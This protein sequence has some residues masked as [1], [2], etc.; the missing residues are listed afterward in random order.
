MKK[1]TIFISIASYRDDVCALTIKSLFEMAS[2]P[3]NVY[4]GICQ[5][6]KKEDQDCYNQDN[7]N[8][9]IIR[10]PHYEAR[11]PTYARYLCSTL[12]NGEEYYLQIDSHTKFV[13]DWDVKCIEM[14]RK[15]KEITKKPVL[16]H[17]PRDMKDYDE[18]NKHELPRIC[19]AFF[20]DRGMIS[21]AGSEIMDSKNQF[22][23]TP[24]I[25]AGM[26]FC[27]S[28]FLNELPFDPN[29]PYLFTGE[30]ILLSVRFY[31]NGWDIYTPTENVL[32]HEY[33]R[34]EK[35]KIWS[36]DSHY[37]DY[38]AVNKVKYYLKLKDAGKISKEMKINIDKYGLGKSRTLEDYYKFAGI[39]IKNNKVSKNFCNN[40]EENFTILY[41][42]N[43]NYFFLFFFFIL[44]FILLL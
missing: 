39:D 28:Y 22:Y 38:E 8:V 44:F 2:R 21:F 15:L 33:T 37:S 35:P 17:Y 4:V 18:K 19:K 1:D 27:E 3:E 36:D 26:F 32:F 11:G 12:W 42:N 23:N 25:A 41:N 13:K 31:T 5:Q 9:R 24:F 40:I 20:N 14:I 6:N 34:S 7:K 29:L 43:C 10:L 30:E 16:S